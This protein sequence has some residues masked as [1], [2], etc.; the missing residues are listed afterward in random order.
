MKNI[1]SIKMLAATALL[2]SALGTMTVP[3]SAGSQVCGNYVIG[4]ASKNWNTANKI[5]KKVGGFVWDL[6]LSNSP[7]A[8]KGFWVVADGPFS[9][10]RAKR[11]VR[12][13]KNN[14]ASGAYRKNM[15]FTGV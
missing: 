11:M 2:V 6:D 15:C 7:N 14:G 8:G 10:S 13:W 5:A 1:Q 3:A 4:L 12:E 9:V